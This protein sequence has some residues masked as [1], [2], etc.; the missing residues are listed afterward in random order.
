MAIRSADIVVEEI[1]HRKFA[2][3]NLQSP[4]WKLG[5]QSERAARNLHLL[6]GKRNDLLE[7]QARDV[8]SSANRWV[9]DDIEICESRQTQRAADAAPS[10]LFD[11]EINHR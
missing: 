3:T 10:R 7:H 5:G 4:H 8:G 6:F 9:A 2:E 1:G 11:V